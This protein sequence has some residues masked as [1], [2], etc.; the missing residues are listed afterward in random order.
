MDYFKEKCNLSFFFF[1]SV[2]DCLKTEIG[3]KIIKPIIETIEI[4]V[5]L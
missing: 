4:I 1:F 3:K 5:L 2:A